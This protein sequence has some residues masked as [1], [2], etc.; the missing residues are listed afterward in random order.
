MYGA[1]ALEVVPFYRLV[2]DNFKYFLEVNL[3]LKTIPFCN[4]LFE[5]CFQ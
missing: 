5:H 4:V 3:A 2:S 1:T